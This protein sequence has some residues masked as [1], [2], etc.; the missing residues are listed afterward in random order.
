M[1]EDKKTLGQA[2]IQILPTTEGI[3][4][5]LR[6]ALGGASEEAGRSAGVGF[7]SF[8][9]DMLKANLV[10]EGVKMVVDGTRQLG[11][12]VVDLAKNAV[13]SYADYEQ[14]VGGV[15]TLFKTSADQV[16]QY[17]SQAYKT[18][19]LSAN[20]YMETVTSFSASL[21][22]SLG[23][24]TKA[25][26]D[27]ADL[28]ITDMSDNANKMGTDMSAIQNAYQG[29]A[30]QNYSMLDNL[31]LGYGGT[32]TEMYRLL[33]DAAGL[34]DE[35]A[36]TA[37]FSLNN[38]GHLEAGY[39]DIVRAIH[40]VQTEMGITGTTAA[41]AEHTIS[42]S[43]ASMR[44]AWANLVTGMADENADFDQLV[45]N[46]VDSALIA[47]DNLIPRIEQ[48]L[49]GV[50]KLIDGLAPVIAAKLPEL[51]QIILPPIINA[52]GQIVAALVSALPTLA[53]PVISAILQ[54]IDTLGAALGD[55]VPALSFIFD[56]LSGIIV[57][58]VAAFGA[59]K[60]I[61]LAQQVATAATTIAQGAL[62]LAMLAN[63][64][65][66]VVVAIGALVAAVVHLWNTNENFR[67]FVIDCWERVKVAFS[68]LFDALS[69]L[70]DAMGLDFGTF[71]DLVRMIW[72]GLCNFLA[73]LLEGQLFLVVTILENAL[74]LLT[75][76]LNTFSALFRG[77]YEAF[78][79]GIVE[80]TED[81]LNTLTFGA[82][83]WGKDLVSSLMNG[84]REKLPQ[85]KE[86]ISDV[87]QTVKRFIHFSEPD[88]GPLSNFHTYAPDMMRLFAQGIKDN[89]GLV[90]SQMERSFALPEQNN[91]KY[92]P[93]SMPTRL[94]GVNEGA[95][96]ALSDAS[97]SGSNGRP[98]TVV[99]QMN[100]TEWG[101]GVFRL[102][103]Q[104]KQRIGVRLA[105]GAV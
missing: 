44:S 28:A 41:E 94:V 53:E 40:I 18:A 26:A 30:K 2:Y 50:G 67:D 78:W 48:A 81:V 89:E 104:E 8:F 74:R 32:Q 1:A 75:E 68:G 20:E 29:F 42:G 34:N 22:Q 15:E 59:F 17:A 63:P 47:G 77:D 6:Q 43:I 19:G 21:L 58:V 84:L 25:A 102:Y 70:L 12:A 93:A 54:A 56:N 80:F 76:A 14:L 11:E 49:I 13:S 16:Q 100:E 57:G 101:R 37:D 92:Q 7:S 9:G 46:F 52:A 24:D 73:P 10:T 95:L 51:V 71:A 4:D 98:V 36:R 69:G 39:A 38:K 99:L 27:M 33:Q 31:K 62:N 55:K 86:T 87:A 35:F 88:E 65:G 66:L 105:K 91:M 82:Y 61:L 3:A 60:A 90:R 83:G 5:Q 79:N 23:G 85:L 45:Q 103:E 97:G 72:D 64:A 96:Q